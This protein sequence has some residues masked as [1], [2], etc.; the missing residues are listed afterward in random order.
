MNPNSARRVVLHE[1][2][3]GMCH[4]ANVAFLELTKLG[5]CS[6]GSVMVPCPWFLEMADAVAA[7]PTLDLG[8]HLTINAEKRYYKWRPLTAPPQSSGLVDENGFFW[9]D[10][11]T[12]RSK[13]APEAVEAE[14]RAQIEAAYRAGI[15]PT[16]ID[17]H[18]G[19]AISP[20]FCDIFVRLGHEY[21]LPVLL[22]PTVAV[23]APNDN[24]VGVTEA[25]FAPGV[26]KARGLGFTIFDR[27]VET[28]WRRPASTPAEP[29]YKAI[30]EGIPEGLTF[31]C[32][33]FNTP[34]ELAFIEPEAQHTRSQ[35]YQLFRSE[36][37]RDW[38][39]AQDLNVIGMR[40]FRAELRGE[41]GKADAASGR[42]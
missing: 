34:E 40:A 7:D 10:V 27:V 30:I 17:G 3:V 22:T 26:E 35:E 2:D 11:A 32:L 6:S 8:V 36:G 5:V 31:F 39:M 20:E 19:A 41:T 16:H 37:F 13:A 21:R 25:A 15:E 4:G 33:H 42:A 18:M 24:L 1:D 14:F 29:A 28:T 12:T 23:Y 38:L 9:P